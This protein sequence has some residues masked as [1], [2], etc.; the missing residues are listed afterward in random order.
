MSARDN[1]FGPMYDAI[2]AAYPEATRF[3]W[4]EQMFG[5]SEWLVGIPVACG[6]GPGVF[7]KSVPLSALN[8]PLQQD[9]ARE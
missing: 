8:P 6:G 1:H 7:W 9:T 5:P 3:H 4:S 2:R